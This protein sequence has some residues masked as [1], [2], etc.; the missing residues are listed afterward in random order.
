MSEIWLIVR[1]YTNFRISSD[2][3]HFEAKNVKSVVN[4]ER[5]ISTI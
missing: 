2:D 3:L 4:L 5:I 1:F